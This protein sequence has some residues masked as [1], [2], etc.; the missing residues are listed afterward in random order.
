[1]NTEYTIKARATGCDALNTTAPTIGAAVEAFAQ[2][3]DRAGIGNSDFRDARIMVGRKV[4]GYLSFNGRVWDKPNSEW[5][6]GDQPIYSP[7]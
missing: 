3:R 5:Q 2:W 7:F 1:M 4:A 6:Y